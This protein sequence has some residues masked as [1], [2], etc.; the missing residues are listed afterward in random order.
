MRN[1][2]TDAIVINIDDLKMNEVQE[3]TS[4][5]R[6][7][8]VDEDNTILVANYGGVY[9]LPGGS[10]DSGETKEQAIIRELREEI[11]QD[12][13]KEELEYFICLRYFQKNYPKRNGTFQNR[14]VETYYF[15]GKMKGILKSSQALTDKEKQDN[16]K[17]ELF[18]LEELEKVILENTNNNPRNLYFQ[19]ELMSII[20]VYKDSR[21]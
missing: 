10:I 6:A 13:N 16:F 21:K 20:Q 15:V 1:K 2:N 7:I 8:L 11:G 4:K 18:C 14:L 19:R 5:V 17:L 12:Y 9:L 3:F